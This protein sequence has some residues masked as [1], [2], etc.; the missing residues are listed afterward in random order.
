MRAFHLGSTAS[1]TY[2]L[3]TEGITD[4][5]ECPTAASLEDVEVTVILV[6]QA[7]SAWV[8]MHEDR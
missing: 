5:Q 2:P 7:V 6:G 4:D 1:G 3:A 8:S